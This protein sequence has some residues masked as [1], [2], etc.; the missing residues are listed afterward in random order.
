[1]PVSA[2]RNMTQR[3]DAMVNGDASGC[4]AVHRQ[5]GIPRGRGK[6]GTNGAT[7]DSFAVMSGT[8]SSDNAVQD[9]E[10]SAH[11]VGNRTMVDYTYRFVRVTPD[12]RCAAADRLGEG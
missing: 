5:R 2:V 11:E 9:T 7:S 8:R 12:W 6:S 10:R 4:I 1:M 3:G